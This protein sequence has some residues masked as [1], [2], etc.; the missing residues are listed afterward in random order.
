MVAGADGITPRDLLPHAQGIVAILP[1][2]FE[3]LAERIEA[4]RHGDSTPRCLRWRH[5][6]DI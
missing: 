2:I 5:R 1:P 4:D 3:E 6:C